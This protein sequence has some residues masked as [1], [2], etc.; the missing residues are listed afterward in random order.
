[1]QLLIAYSF[2][3][4]KHIIVYYLVAWIIANKKL[5]LTFAGIKIKAVQERKKSKQI[6]LRWNRQITANLPFLFH[7]H[8][9]VSLL[10]LLTTPRKSLI[11]IEAFEERTIRKQTILWN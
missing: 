2:H 6:S 5:L 1:M 3:S 10:S 11:Y 4:H 9:R 7:C 8:K